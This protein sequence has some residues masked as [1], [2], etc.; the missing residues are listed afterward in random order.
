MGL[1]NSDKNF[2]ELAE[3]EQLKYEYQTTAKEI[4]E[5]C[6]AFCEMDDD[7]QVFVQTGKTFDL[8]SVKIKKHVPNT[9]KFSIFNYKN[10]KSKRFVRVLKCDHEN[11]VKNLFRKWHNFFDHL[12]IHTSEKPYACH[13]PGCGVSFT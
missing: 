13:Y 9:K 10:P 6:D 8:H 4:R 3:I 12:R 1:C 7:L 5:E 2:I 11:C